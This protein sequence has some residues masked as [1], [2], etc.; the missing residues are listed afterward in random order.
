[1]AACICGAPSVVGGRPYA[2]HNAL[3]NRRPGAKDMSE[4]LLTDSPSEHIRVLTMNRP[5]QLNAMSAEL[6]EALHR[7]LDRLALERSCRAIVITGA[8]RGFCA[9][10]DLRGYGDA[11][12]NDG[13]DP[14]RDRLG[15]QQHMSRLI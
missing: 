8:G 3:C 12:G 5:D 15:N 6:C 11:P 2:P 1:M 13:S 4:I 14:A 10:V 7:E 9:G